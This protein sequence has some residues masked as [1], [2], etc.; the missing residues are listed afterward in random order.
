MLTR[1]QM[2]QKYFE[3]D[4]FNNKPPLNNSYVSPK[5]RVNHPTF[6]RTK[7]DVFNI[8]K[9]NHIQ[10]HR[11][12]RV[13]T[14]TNKS[15]NRLET[16]SKIYGSDIFNRVPF[17]SNDKNK[18]GRMNRLS[19]KNKSSC[20]D[21]VKDNKEYIKVLKKY[22]TEHRAPKNE[23]RPEIFLKTET[24]AE[25]YYKD[26]YD[27]HGMV[28]L[29]ESNNDNKN[30][31]DYVHNRRFLNKELEKINN[32][33][34]DKNRLDYN[35]ARYNTEENLTNKFGK[36][37]FDWMEQK[38]KNYRYINSTEY[39]NNNCQI[40][41][42]L[43]L[44]SNVLNSKNNN[45]DEDVADINSRIEHKKHKVYNIDVMGNPK[46]EINRN[47]SEN[48]R[49][50]IN[51]VHSK[52]QKTNI[53]WLSPETE[54]MFNKKN[55]NSSPFQRKMNQLA[56]TKNKDTITGNKNLTSINN[57]QKP[58]KFEEIN[59]D[60]SQKIDEMMKNIPNIGNNRKL[61]IKMKMSALE[62][63]DD[64][65]N[66]AKT[67]S[68]FYKKNPNGVHKQKQ[69][70]TRKVNERIQVNLKKSNNVDYQDY[71]LTYGTKDK[72]NFEKYSENEIKK[73]FGAKGVQVYDVHKNP[74]D[75]GNYNTVNFKVRF[76]NKKLDEVDN[77]IKSVQEDLLKQNYKVNIKKDGDKKFGKNDKELF[78]NPG[79]KVSIMLD[80]ASNL[81]NTKYQKIPEN[82]RLKKG[83]S[84]QFVNV[85]YSYK[86]PYP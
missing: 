27:L 32:E 29:P 21:G 59:S 73:I 9:K 28:V 48:D 1:N 38:K 34:V 17:A 82:V 26:H 37:K 60:A 52:W 44:S 53:N 74:F 19:T 35:S 78:T 20:M 12:K 11:E 55:E 51:S 31:A 22:E 5:I 7:K 16:Y 47:F 68:E 49:D 15:V 24:P 66:K 64:W 13:I 23:Y 42:Q 54:L 70:I 71:L 63:D 50:L 18:K 86:N 58:L 25:R 43:E 40:N 69:E 4:I 83:F 41:R 75:K 39:P 14:R 84:K 67:V 62:C 80:K 45:F 85:N 2:Y 81:K 57:L 36:K 79:A 33:E 61:V 72:N 76:D 56:D 30:L 46:K 10:R 77:K 3:S 8:D 65:N 6:E